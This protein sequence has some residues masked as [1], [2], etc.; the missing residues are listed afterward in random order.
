MNKYLI[1]IL[2]LAASIACFAQDPA[3]PSSPP[4]PQNIIAAEYYVDTD[5]GFGNGT[6]ITVT[7]GVTIASIN[8][9]V[10]TTGLSNGVHRVVVRTRNQ[11]G[12]WSI[13]NVQDFIVDFDPAYPLNPAPQ[14]ITAAEYFID[15]DPGFGNGTAISITA[16]V[17]INNLIA[18]VNTTGLSAGTHRIY[19]RSRNNEGRW[20]ITNQ[21]DFIVDFDPAYPTAPA[22]PQNITQMEYF[23]NTDPGIGNGTAISI[24]PALNINNLIAG[25]N[26]SSLSPGTTNRLYLRSRNNEGS[27]SITNIGTFVVDIV[28]DPVYPPAPPA[29]GNITYAEYFFD[30]DPG[31][32][33]GTLIAITPGVDINNLTI[34]TNTASLPAGT[35]RLFVRSFDDW[36]ITAVQSFNI[37]SALPLRFLSFTAAGS[38]D[39]VL[40]NWDTD[41]EDNTS[42]FDV[43]FSTDGRVFTKIGEVKAMNTAGTHQYRFVHVSPAGSVLYYRIKQV[44][45][46]GKFEYSSIARVNMSKADKIIL[47]PNPAQNEAVLL[48]G[49]PS[50]KTNLRVL[51]G[52]G[53]VVLQH[54]INEGTRQYRVDISKLPSG[55]YIIELNNNQKTEVIKLVKQN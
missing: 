10:N 44:D 20:A 54:Q 3:Y 19:I 13:S 21:K 14:N 41:N 50:A 29:P 48:F 34:S 23:I 2:L 35:H 46:D 24:T 42:H 16:A 45:Q 27:W 40:L 5:P 11:E 36:S 33:N 37:L 12:N 28:N 53:Q 32:G 1:T 51:N 39:D 49:K 30:T 4:A 25:I 9:S 55:I 22:A 17:D 38:N 52:S 8:V 6:A 47:S 31:F 26:T 18:A 7:P 15:T 43:E